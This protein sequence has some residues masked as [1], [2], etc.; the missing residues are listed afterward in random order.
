MESFNM[1]GIFDSY[2][3]ISPLIERNNKSTPFFQDEYEDDEFQVNYYPSP[4]Y[5]SEEGHNEN[6][7]VLEKQ[8]KSN[9]EEDSLSLSIT[10]KLSGIM[11]SKV[12]VESISLE[13]PE[14]DV[15][16]LQNTEKNSKTGEP[17]TDK[18]KFVKIESKNGKE[19]FGVKTNKTIEMLPRID[20]AIKN[21]KVT[22]VKYIKELGNN[23]IKEC[24]F[25]NELKNLKLFSPSN[26]YFTG[27]SN[28]KENNIFLDFTVGQIFCHPNDEF[29]K[30]NRLQRNNKKIIAKITDYIKSLKEVPKKYEKVINF[31]DMTFEEAIILFYKSDKFKEYKEDERA[32]YLD[33]QFIK[34]KGFSI[35][36]PNS[37]I[38]MMRHNF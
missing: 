31:F 18:S 9:Q 29:G 10:K 20:Y 16:I 13:V 34:V 8:E 17:T 19:I 32:K 11:Q 35:F 23:L 15:T 22:L 1:K 2:P 26:K 37:F 28:E 6:L 5:Q 38:K 27:I 3:D 21:F 30:D 33:N 36:E 14:Y 4:K 7:E 25:G 12:F 24:K